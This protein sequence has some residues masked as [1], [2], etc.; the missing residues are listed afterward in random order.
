[1]LGGLALLVQRC[2]ADPEVGVEQGHCNRRDRDK[3]PLPHR[4]VRYHGT[5]P[6]QG[7]DEHAVE[8]QPRDEHV[9][10]DL[11]LHIDPGHQ[12]AVDEQAEEDDDGADPARV[13]V[14]LRN[15]GARLE[16]VIGVELRRRV[17]Q[18][19]RDVEQGGC[20]PQHP[21]EERRTEDPLLEADAVAKLHEG[22]LSSQKVFTIISP[23]SFWASLLTIFSLQS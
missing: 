7:K 17:Q 14:V 19:I 13:V 21:G 10:L 15:H 3:L 16:G 18:D 4:V 22:V 5:D 9:G 6:N 11:V 2:N 20:Q 1:M 23:N 12:E 8:N